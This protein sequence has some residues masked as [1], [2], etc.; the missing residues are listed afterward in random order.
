MPTRSSNTEPDLVALGP[1][2]TAEG[3]VSDRREQG[4]VSL[5]WFPSVEGLLGGG[6]SPRK[7]GSASSGLSGR[8][9]DTVG[10]LVKALTVLA[11]AA[12]DNCTGFGAGLPRRRHAANAAQ[13][14]AAGW[15]CFP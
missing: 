10:T 7:T 12:P 3:G 14:G 13:R 1:E 11:L 15:R 4:L 9:S 2:A 5:A 6:R 8:M